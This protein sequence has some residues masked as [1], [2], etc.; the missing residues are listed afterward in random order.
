MSRR[1]KSR[2]ASRPATVDDIHEVARSLPGVTIDEGPTVYQVSRRTFIFFRNPR[3]DAVDPET[4]E[5]YTDVIVFWVESDLE[6]EAILADTSLPFFTTPHFNGHNSVL[7]R[8]SRIAELSREDLVGFVERAWLARAG[9]RAV[10][11]FGEAKSAT[12]G[13]PILRSID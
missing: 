12:A 6:K 11:K 1:P 3:P 7:L 8:G 2:R 13:A 9:P 10:R 5:R 4:G